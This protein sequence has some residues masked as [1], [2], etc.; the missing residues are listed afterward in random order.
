MKR[1]VNETVRTSF[2]VKKI[3]N[4]KLIFARIFRILGHLEKL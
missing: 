3:L 1:Y 4:T 2:D